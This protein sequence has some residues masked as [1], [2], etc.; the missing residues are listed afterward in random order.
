M[1]VSDENN[2]VIYANFGTRTR[3]TSPDDVTRVDTTGF[4][5]A[6]NRLWQSVTSQ[7]DQ[8]RIKRGREYAGAGNVVELQVRS[9]S[10]SAAVAGSQNDPFNVQ[11][12]LPYRSPEEINS[13]SNTLARTNNGMSRARRGEFT[14]ELLDLLL[15]GDTDDIRFSCDCPDHVRACKHAV[16]STLKLA[17]KMDADPGVVFQLRGMNLDDLEK[18]VLTDSI[19]VAAESTEEGSSLFFT[20]RELPEL[21][22][23]KTAPALDDS[24]L[25]LLHKAM[26][27]VSFTNVD[28]LRAVSD[29]EELYD[30]LTDQ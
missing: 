13:I 15:A 22:D 14:G 30:T 12:I 23:P 29:I 27:S 20:G 18:M 6:A 11:I 16:A 25:D 5:Q 7:A 2:N 1:A 17:E 9:G 4:G 21:P 8:G 24:D 19:S 28:Q 10:A 3:V 26:R